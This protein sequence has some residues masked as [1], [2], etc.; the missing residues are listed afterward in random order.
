MVFEYL[1]KNQERIGII[2]RDGATP[3]DIDFIKALLPEIEIM[4]KDMTNSIK[5]ST[6]RTVNTLMAMT[7]FDVPWSQI[8]NLVVDPTTFDADQTRWLI[9]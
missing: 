7:D 8:E 2:I 9:C 5:G 4:D 1:N 6:F 3:D